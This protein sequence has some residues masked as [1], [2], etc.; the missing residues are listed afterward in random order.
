MRLG[1]V[2]ELRANGSQR[3]AMSCFAGCCRFA[4]NNVLAENIADYEDF[5]D[6]LEMRQVWGEASSLEE[7]KAITD[8]LKPINSFTFNYAV[9]NLKNAKGNEFLKD[10]YS[11]CLQS[12]M[13]DLY[14]A[15]S[16]FFEGKGG[17]P[18]YQR[19]GKND[20][21]NYPDGF[22]VDESNSRIYLP[23]IGWVRYRKSQE[24]FGTPKNVT[25]SRR[26]DKWFVSIQT[27]FELQDPIPIERAMLTACGI[28]MGVVNFATLS[29][30]KVFPSLT[31]KLDRIEHRIKVTQKRLSHKYQEGKKQQSS[32]NFS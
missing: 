22:K 25:V 30:G 27:E 14:E 4:W 3:H 21:F 9:G 19:K 13:G 15:Y 24:I 2:F 26:V 7:A 8:K 16:R 12:K 17:F 10:C 6:D 31:E 32:L 28:D 20:S 11:H 18:K 29:N 1:F 23:K 5:K